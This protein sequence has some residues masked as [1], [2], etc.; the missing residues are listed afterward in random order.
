MA[1]SAMDPNHSTVAP[2]ESYAG[3][4]CGGLVHAALFPLYGAPKM[5]P[6]EIETEGGDLNLR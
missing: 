5:A 3:F 4:W 6:I 2:H 1:T